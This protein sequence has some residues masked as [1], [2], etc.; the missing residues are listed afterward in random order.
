MVLLNFTDCFPVWLSFYLFFLVLISSYYLFPSFPEFLPFVCV[1]AWFSPK[2]FQES[3]S[4]FKV[5]QEIARNKDN[6]AEFDAR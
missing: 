6:K 2:D 1:S 5:L 3:P 4:Q